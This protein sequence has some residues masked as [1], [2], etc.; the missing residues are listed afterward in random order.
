MIT[1]DSYII[2]SL[3]KVKRFLGSFCCLHDHS[4][5]NDDLFAAFSNRVSQHLELPTRCLSARLLMG[6]QCPSRIRVT[7]CNGYLFGFKIK[8]PKKPHTRTHSLPCLHYSQGLP[9]IST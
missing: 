7:Q 1:A 2:S 8:P 4:T 6:F 9:G 3:G 5:R